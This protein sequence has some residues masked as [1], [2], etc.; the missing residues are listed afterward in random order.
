MSGP[1]EEARLRQLL[2][3]LDDPSP[4]TGTGV[5]AELLRYGDA[6]LPL[7]AEIQE[8]DDPVLRRRIHQLE[9]ILTVRRRRKAFLANLK[10]GPADLVQGL[11]DV[12]LLWFDNDSRPALEEMFQ[13]FLEVA[14]NNGIRNIEDLAGFMLRS[15]FCV[16]S[17]GELTVP[18]NYCIGTILEDRIGSDIMLCVIALLVGAEAGLELGLVRVMGQFAVINVAGVMIVPGNNWQSERAGKLRKGDFWNDPKAV[19]K[20]AS[21]M[22]FLYAVGSDSF[23]YIHTIGHSLVGLDDRTELDFLPYPY[24]GKAPEES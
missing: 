23:R 2:S 5:L 13:S 15:G 18:E 24:G 10:T 17:A 1:V 9:S 12:H 20:Y 11:I 14:A 3:L 4:E 6:V 22:L 21:L 19:L 16:P 8:S 7:L